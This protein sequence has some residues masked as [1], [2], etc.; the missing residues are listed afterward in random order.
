MSDAH[1]A[2][3]DGTTTAVSVVAASKATMQ[4]LA[5][6]LARGDRTAVWWQAD[7]TQFTLIQSY[8]PS[9]R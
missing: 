5:V 3:A 1:R 6:A 7:E 9:P 2:N 8:R 4:A